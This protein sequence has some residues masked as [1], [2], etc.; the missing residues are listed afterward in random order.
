MGRERAAVRERD[1]QEVTM[2]RAPDGSHPVDL[3]GCHAWAR[4]EVHP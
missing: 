3:G 4:G 2:S 1:A